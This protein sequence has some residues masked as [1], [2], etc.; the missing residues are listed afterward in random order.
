MWVCAW[1]GVWVYVGVVCGWVGVVWLG[2]CRCGCVCLWVCVSQCGNMGEGWGLCLAVRGESVN[3]CLCWGVG[4]IYICWRGD[5][6][7]LYFALPGVGCTGVGCACPA[8]LPGSPGSW[9]AVPGSDSHAPNHF[10]GLLAL[11]R[12]YTDVLTFS[13]KDEA[14]GQWL[15]SPRGHPV[16]QLPRL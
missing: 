8:S 5:L 2:G 3:V 15:G 9:W 6:A 16:A 12:V 14:C 10:P 13:G 7:S 11:P 4:C 1:V